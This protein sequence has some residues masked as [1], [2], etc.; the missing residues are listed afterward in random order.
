MRILLLDHFNRHGG[1]QEYLLD[2]AGGLGSCGVEAHIPEIQLDSLRRLVTGSPVSTGFP[3][4]SATFQ[5][6]RFYLRFLL[7]IFQI[8]RYCRCA[9]IDI[10]QC[11]SIPALPL[12]RLSVGRRLPIIF[13]CHDCNLSPFRIALIRS[14]ADSVICV[15]D[16]VRRYLLDRG[17]GVPMT[18]I[19]NGFHDL[20]APSLPVCSPLSTTRFGLIGRLERWKGGLLFVEAAKECIRRGI[21][22]EFLIVGNG[23][24]LG[25]IDELEKSVAGT[26]RI[27]LI[28]F[29][30][31][32]GELYGRCDVVVNSSI[33]CEPFGRTLVE[34]ALFSLPVI[35]PDACGPREICVDGETGRLFTSGNIS[36]LA[37]AMSELA[38]NAMAREN[39]GR[40]GRL[41]YEECYSINAVAAQFAAWCR[42]RQKK[43]S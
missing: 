16:T 31:D 26:P 32:K 9:A 15:S 1:A 43:S 22:A 33:E 34:A 5:S 2:I 17:V 6:I 38:S 7:N 18:V 42:G 21:D 36:S 20:P 30:A 39:M 41:R 24:D 29:I 13:T 25:Y 10:V 35:G 12:A 23:E 11:N 40:K 28:P 14:C 37:D 4:L 27:Q 19:N 8:R 3:I